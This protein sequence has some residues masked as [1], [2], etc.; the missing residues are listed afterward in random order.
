MTF[1]IRKFYQFV[2]GKEQQ[3]VLD[4]PYKS[5]EQEHR[6]DTAMGTDKAPF[7]GKLVGEDDH[8]MSLIRD[9]ENHIATPQSLAERLAT[10]YHSFKEAIPPVTSN[11]TNPAPGTPAS[12][13]EDQPQVPGQPAG[14]QKPA[15]PGQP[16]VKPGETADDETAIA[17]SLIGKNYSQIQN[18]IPSG[19]PAAKVVQ[20]LATANQGTTLD[21]TQHAALAP[22]TQAV[23]K[24]MGNPQAAAQFK[25]A[26]AKVASS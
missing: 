18:M 6:P 15:V 13:A 1:D 19:Q 12:D 10:A 11:T 21:P 2:E 23:A 14:T 22:L 24:A 4:K 7:K 3:A 8:S 9:L 20:A 5:A 25:A 16:A 26:L 17:T